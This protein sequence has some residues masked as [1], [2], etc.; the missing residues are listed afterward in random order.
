MIISALRWMNEWIRISTSAA[1]TGRGAATM[2][3][4]SLVWSRQ[5]TKELIALYR[6]APC[7]W[8]ITSKCYKDRIKRALALTQIETQLKDVNGASTEEIRKKIHILRNQ[9]R[10]E[11]KRETKAKRTGTLADYKPSLWCYNDLIFLEEIADK[12]VTLSSFEIVTQVC[13]ATWNI[14]LLFKVSCWIK[15]IYIFI[16]TWYITPMRKCHNSKL[17]IILL[18]Y[19]FWG[20]TIVLPTE[21]RS[22]VYDL[23]TFM[24]FESM[25]YYLVYW[26]LFYL[27]SF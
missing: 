18:Q 27:Y 19:I 15:E 17:A 13:V 26:I 8:K 11:R 21:G 5:A 3:V 22:H 25:M 24:Y 16:I 2:P 1:V 14:L 7:L 12:L 6:D 23:V 4:V 10:S 20:M 9:F